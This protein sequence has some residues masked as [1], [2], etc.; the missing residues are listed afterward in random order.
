MEI[1]TSYCYQALNQ[2]SYINL[3]A[4]AVTTPATVT[5]HPGLLTIVV[6]E[7]ASNDLGK[8]IDDNGL[9]FLINP[10]D[11]HDENRGEVIDNE[12]TDANT[13]RKIIYRLMEEKQSMA[14]KHKN[15]ID[16]ITEK[17]DSAKYDR[18]MYLKMYSEASRKA[19]RVKNQVQ[20]IAVLV[21]SIFPEK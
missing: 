2:G 19:D 4:Y 17:C 1:K 5:L 10:I 18:D 20:A 21:N 16:E 15:V 7:D 3:A 13:L 8:F 6:S 11:V 14:Q 12:I 9:N